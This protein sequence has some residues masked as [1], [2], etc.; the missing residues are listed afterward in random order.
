MPRFSIVYPTRHRPEF[1]REALRVLALQDFHDFEIVV[2]D[3]F[4]DPQLSCEA[5]CRNAR[6][7]V[8]Y[9]RPP[10]A[11]GMVE[12]WNFALT[13]ATGEYVCVLTDKMFFLPHALRQ[14]D[15]VAHLEGDPEIINWVS[16]AF[17]PTSTADYFGA[18]EYVRYFPSSEIKRLAEKFD[19]RTELDLKGR[20]EV[21]RSEQSNSEYSR[22]KILFGFFHRNL[23]SRIKSRFDDV[24]HN[25]S[26]DYTS[27]ILALSTARSAVEMAESCVVSINT[28]ISNG[29][30][31]DTD[32]SAALA[33]Q[34]S[35]AGGLQ[36]IFSNML[37]PGMYSSISNVVAHDYL[38][39]QRKYDLAFE[40]DATNWLVYC[41]EEVGRPQRVWSSPEVGAEQARLLETH[42]ASLAPE[43][44]DSFERIA[45][46]RRSGSLT[47]REIARSPEAC[48]VPSLF[49]G[50]VARSRDGAAIPVDGMLVLYHHPDGS[51]A[52]T[53]S[54]HVRSFTRSAAMPVWL[55][56]TEQK[57]PAGLWGL[58]FRVIVIHYS[59]AGF[60][61]QLTARAA[62]D[63]RLFSEYVSASTGAFKI[64]F[65]QDEYHHCPGRFEFIKRAGIDVIFSLLEPEEVPKVY[66]TYTPGV[67]VEYTL[68]GYVSD[69][70][71]EKARRWT[72]PQSQRPID[73]GYRA[74][75][76]PF[77]MGRGSQEKTGIAD[78]FV[79]RTAQLPLRLDV[80]TAEEDRIYG[81]D[82]YRFI[83][84]C[85]AMLGVEAGV[86]V[87]DLDDGARSACDAVLAEN[88][89]ADFA[90]VHRLALAPYEGRIAY[91]TVS[92]RVFEAAAFRTCLVLFEGRYSGVLQPMVH[93]IPLKKDFSNLEEVLR[94]LQDESAVNQITERAYQDLI[95]S[96]AYSYDAF[97]AGL[98]DI[99]TARVGSFSMRRAERAFV[100]RALGASRRH[101]W[102]RKW[103]AYKRRVWNRLHRPFPGKRMLKPLLK[104]LVQWYFALSHRRNH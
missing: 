36:T 73:V 81:D 87:F 75:P 77:Y 72:R 67:P 26:P 28:P 8:K 33:F 94:L 49:E 11:V 54:D 61:P 102:Q 47:R 21:A 101:V 30:L 52:Q 13:H 93:Y 4:V 90:T 70:L 97:I 22:G 23:I 12:N 15:A 88:P 71:V 38:A 42:L 65:F 82:W 55:V 20:G 25:I 95:A 60:Y 40:F 50:V 19:P 104:P 96:G 89:D 24:F 57:F 78:E 64:A 84:N 16:D 80:K 100:T 91:R 17:N 56:N 43:K 6:V 68:T 51:S 79:R 29:Y 59:L 14:I 27:M 10:Q 35:L 76:L 39:M 58:K 62:E 3:N 18:G 69:D 41:A 63:R 37:V 83:G 46:R 5:A 45:A 34:S 31:C 2:S 53:I 74:R 7:A 86:S 48:V 103:R 66:G 99:L 44:R 32:D 9:V 85:R 92:P 1:I 98:D